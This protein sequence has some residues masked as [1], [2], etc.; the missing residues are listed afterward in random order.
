MLKTTLVSLIV[1][2][3]GALCT[4]ATSAAEE[5]TVEQKATPAP[6]RSGHLKLNGIN[7]YY[8]V[9][10]DG[11]PVLLLHGGLGI[12]EM[13]GPNLAK[14][15]ES[16]Q[17]IGVDLQ[18]HGRTPL[19]NRRIDLAAM[20]ADMG[21]LVKELGY[22]QVDVLGYSM[23]GGVALQMAAQAPGSVRRLVLVSTP[24]AKDGFYPEMIAAQAQVGAGAAEM[25][26]E[27]PM[28]KSYAA[29]APDVSEFPKLL[30]AMGD[31]MR[32][33]YDGSAA[34]AKLTMP[35]MLIY[36]DSDMFRLEHVVDF[37]HKL[38]GGLKDAGWMRE[39]M[40]K[41]RLAILPDLTHYD[42]FVSPKLLEAA[43]PFL[44]GESGAKSWAEEVRGK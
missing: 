30:D 11:E 20:G 40:S 39:N 29:V 21:A 23:G 28:Y 14:L 41:N 9:Y 34:V 1:A 18:G 25:M 17:V 24:Y 36:G 31:L 4:P 38:G 16:R 22:E 43:L 10:G 15:A 44:N 5:A 8:Q 26:K 12:I 27:T 19:G 33:D 6:T 37:Y 7:Y 35:V 42:I 2:T 32:R 13:F 3:I